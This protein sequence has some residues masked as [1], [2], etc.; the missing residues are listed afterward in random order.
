LS[1]LLHVRYLCLQG[2]K[3]LLAK[4]SK[5]DAMFVER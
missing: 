2:V 1:N 4:L 3:T 5:I